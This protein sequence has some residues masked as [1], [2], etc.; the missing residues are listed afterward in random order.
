MQ[1]ALEDTIAA[2]ATAR[3]PAAVAVVRISGPN[4]FEVAEDLV[5]NLRETCE[6]RKLYVRW[7]TKRDTGEKLDQALVVRFSGPG[8]Y[9][10]EDMVELHCHGGLAVVD[11]VFGALLEAGARPAGP[12]E[13][14]LRAFLA[15]KLDLSQAEAVGRLVEASGEAAAR[16]AL[17]NLAGGLGARVRRLADL[18]RRLRVELEAELEFPDEDLDLDGG[19]WAGR[20]RIVENGLEE[21][22]ADSVAAR[23]VYEGLKVALVGRPNVGKSSLFNRLLG[24]TR[25]VVHHV[26]GTTRDYLSEQM[27]MDGV[28][29]ELLDTAGE[30]ETADEVEAAAGRLGQEAV[31]AADLVLVVV[32]AS[33]Q[34]GVEDRSIWVRWEGADRLLV[35]NKADLGVV[36]AWRDWERG[37]VLSVS[38]KTGE[39]LSEVRREIVSRVGLAGTEHLVVEARQRAALLEAAEALGDARRALE[40]GGMLD[41][42]GTE[43][44]RAEMALR[45]VLGEGVGDDLLDEVFGRFCIGK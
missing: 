12:G 6:P 37:P 8:S 31:S 42:A 25:A 43:M 23:L 1:G 21:L 22:L 18:V 32:D 24:R 17:S 3:M 16:A 29:V 40:L 41:V 33:E 20:A 5:P 36:Q 34:P 26:A 13:F 30:R 44:A 15:G 27:E 38:A 11:R 4:A 28:L 35:L 2:V 10:G 9:T 14:T 39:G 7:L 45:G 19:D